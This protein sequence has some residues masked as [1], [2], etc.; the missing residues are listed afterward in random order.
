[1]GVK[2]VFGDGKLNWHEVV[3]ILIICIGIFVLWGYRVN[4]TIWEQAAIFWGLGVFSLGV[5]LTFFILNLMGFKMGMPISDKPKVFKKK[6]V[7]IIGIIVFLITFMSLFARG[8]D[9]SGTYAI[10]AKVFQVVEPG[11]I[12]LRL[13]EV[14]AAMFENYAF[15]I[16]WASI[17]Y[18]VGG[19][20]IPRLI[21][22]RGDNPILGYIFMLIGVP[23]S[24][25]IYHTA[26][27]G[28]Y[29]IAGSLTTLMFG[30]EM[31]ALT[32]LFQGVFY[33]HAR[34]I[35]NNLG[36]S[37]AKSMGGSFTTLLIVTIFNPI[38]L[39]IILLI[40]VV[41]IIRYKRRKRGGTVI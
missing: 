37:M 38:T 32:I 35:G 21:K 29:N 31:M 13:V 14:F 5:M 23:I 40:A 27:Y 18:V 24:F 2:T 9:P 3:H 30:I 4:T 34:H 25:M 10:Q 39:V 7:Y 15:F 17:L 8:G 11:E 6:W 33:S 19:I 41:L 26:V 22:S 1:M 12:G 28:V 16:A 36:I 20:L